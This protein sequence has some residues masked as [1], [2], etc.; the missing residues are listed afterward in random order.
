MLA[1]LEEQLQEAKNAGKYENW[2]EDEFQCF[3]D[4]H[5]IFLR[6]DYQSM[7]DYIGSKSR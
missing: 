5:Q 7:A 2:T 1:Y 3:V 6:D 4:S